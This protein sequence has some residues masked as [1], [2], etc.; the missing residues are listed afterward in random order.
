MI[1][2]GAEADNAD[3]A[4]EDRSAQ[5]LAEQFDSEI[6]FVG[7]AQHTRH[8]AVAAKCFRILA[9]CQL[10]STTANNVAPG[11]R[12]LR[13]FGIRSMET[14]SVGIFGTTVLRPTR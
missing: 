1:I 4:K 12:S 9:L 3:G 8:N 11:R 5:V 10:V 7:T 6:P 13:C 2:N 14:K